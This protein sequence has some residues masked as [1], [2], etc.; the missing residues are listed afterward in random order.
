[1]RLESELLTKVPVLLSHSCSS[2]GFLGSWPASRFGLAETGPRLLDSE[3]CPIQ[4]RQNVST[5]PQSDNTSEL[6]AGHHLVLGMVM[7]EEKSKGS[8][9][10][11][12]A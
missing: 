11:L 9:P 12:L 5:V 3:S 6:H 1:M 4:R 2:R 10:S 8:K 7:E